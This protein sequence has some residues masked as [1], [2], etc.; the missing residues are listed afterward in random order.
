MGFLVRRPGRAPRPRRLPQLRRHRDAVAGLGAAARR[1]RRAGR[2]RRAPAARRPGGRAEAAAGLVV[3]QYTEERLVQIEASQGY[4]PG[5]KQAAE[6][7][8]QVTLE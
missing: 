7:R 4:K 3:R 6:M 2:R 8:E 5:R 1:T